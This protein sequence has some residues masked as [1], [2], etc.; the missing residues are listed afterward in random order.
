MTDVSTFN[1]GQLEAFNAIQSRS[2]HVTVLGGPAG[3]GKSYVIEAVAEKRNAIVVAPTGVAAIN[4][5]GETI[6]SAFGIRPVL[7]D[8]QADDL[9][10]DGNFR[11]LHDDRERALREADL[12]IIDE[13]SMV[14]ADLLDAVDRRL[15]KVRNEANA[16]FGG[17]QT[18]LVGDSHQLPPVL[19]R[20]MQ[21]AFRSVLD[22]DGTQQ[23]ASE[24]WF[25]SRVI[26]ELMEGGLVTAVRLTV[27]M[28]QDD[29]EFVGFLNRARRGKVTSADLHYINSRV[30]ERPAGVTVLHS[31]RA[32]VD[33][34]NKGHLD[35][36]Y[37][38]NYTYHRQVALID[39]TASW[40]DRHNPA[41]EVR[42]RMGA[43]V[44][45]TTN[46]RE[47]IPERNE[48]ITHWVNGD[49]GRVVSIHTGGLD[50]KLNRTGATHKLR[51]VDFT[52][53]ELLALDGM[54]RGYVTPQ[55]RHTV[56]NGRVR[57]VKEAIAAQVPVRVAAALTIHKSQ[58]Q[59][60][61]AAYVGGDL[62]WSPGLAYVALSRVR[63]L[64]GLY[65]EAP[66]SAASFRVDPRV[67][68]FNKALVTLRDLEVLI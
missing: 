23:W 38:P 22:H 24:W 7:L 20:D 52:R 66:L 55:F 29:M 54:D 9:S 12:L 1:P 26:R 19:P 28:R 60:L 34:I 13:V 62:G 47:Y 39:P 15:R 18:V 68:E 10:T 49:T 33:A 50:I 51:P 61:D 4:V 45:M 25:G 32:G 8:P 53:D 48:V 14:R 40:N 11:S 16:P 63:T 56:V 37:G 5:G 65:L 58:G 59:T 44:S 35:E 57:R 2:H 46:N 30:A 36:L 21:R 64:A 3:V 41:E 42:L 17:L 67:V 31:K 43:L 27:P 6:H